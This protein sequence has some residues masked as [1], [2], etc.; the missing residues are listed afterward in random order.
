[1]RQR[2]PWK[3]ALT[4]GSKL[5][6]TSDCAIGWAALKGTWKGEDFVP[7]GFLESGLSESSGEETFKTA[8]SQ[9][10]KIEH[11][12]KMYR[13]LVA[14]NGFAN[15]EIIRYTRAS[16]H[17]S[18]AAREGGTLEAHNLFTENLAKRLEAEGVKVFFKVREQ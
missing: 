1:M 9:D 3:L 15:V 16:F 8:T 12:V 10:D 13:H 6:G 17:Q 14:D 2:K 18:R 7:T 5:A 11:A 4:F